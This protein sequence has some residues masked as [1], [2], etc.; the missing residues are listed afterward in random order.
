[1]EATG[2]AFEVRSEIWILAVATVTDPWEVLAEIG[3]VCS[4]DDNDNDDDD[5][6]P[7]EETK[8]D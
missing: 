6:E 8:Y 2:L 5:N 3:A 7:D 1:M 4:G